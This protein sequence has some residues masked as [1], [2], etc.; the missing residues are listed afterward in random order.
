MIC[1]SDP[2][3][4]ESEIMEREKI[5]QEYSKLRIF[6][7]KSNKIPN[8]YTEIEFKIEKF[9]E[10]EYRTICMTVGSGESHKIIL[11]VRGADQAWE[12]SGF[13]EFNNFETFL[14]VISNNSELL[15]NPRKNK[16]LDLNALTKMQIFINSEINNFFSYNIK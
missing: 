13:T 5:I 11:A 10:F 9:S 12:K 2:L 14:A 4:E 8:T 15:F 1:F 7:N 6:L 16:I 3:N